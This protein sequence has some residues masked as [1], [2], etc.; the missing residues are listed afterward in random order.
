MTRYTVILL[1]FLSSLFSGFAQNKTDAYKIGL[2]ASLFDVNETFNDL[3]VFNN[4]RPIYLSVT[5]HEK[6][7]IE[8]IMNFSVTDYQ[9]GEDIH[10]A[11]GSFSLAFQYVKPTSK[12]LDI[13]FGSKIGLNSNKTKLVNLHIGGELYLHERWSISNE[14]GANYLIEYDKYFQTTSSVILRF[15][16]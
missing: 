9:D 15:Y 7:R 1:I 11:K 8:S 2:G 12:K 4:S 10:F 16:F 13:Y 14:I 5:I 3:F 6:F